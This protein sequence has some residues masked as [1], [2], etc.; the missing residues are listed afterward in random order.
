MTI[1]RTPDY[2]IPK[3]K[4]YLSECDD[5]IFERGIYHKQ[6]TG[7][8]ATTKE[9]WEQRHSILIFPNKSIAK[10][11]SE[12]PH[13]PK[14][15]VFF[16]YVGS[17]ENKK[18]TTSNEQVSSHHR[19]TSGFTKFFVVADSLPKVFKAIGE[20]EIFK[21]YFLL[22]D[23]IDKYQDQ[24]T[25]RPALEKAIDFFLDPRCNGCLL[26]ATIKHFSN[27]S[28]G[29]YLPAVISKE[30]EQD[31][32]KL[33]GRAFDNLKQIGQRLD[34]LSHENPQK[35]FVIAHKSV[36]AQLAIIS[37]LLDQNKQHCK[38]L[39]G[40]QA[41]SKAKDYYG[42]L[43]DGQ[44]PG[45]FNFITSTYF[46]GVDMYEESI[47]LMVS[48][49]NKTFS[50][51]T[52]KEV[53][54]IY[55]RGRNG[56][57]QAHL[58]INIEWAKFVKVDP[59]NLIDRA[60]KLKPILSNLLSEIKT[61]A[62]LDNS[63]EE[64]LKA[65]I[66]PIKKWNVQ[67]IRVNKENIPDIAHFPIDQYTSWNNDMSQLYSSLKSFKETLGKTFSF[68]FH[69]GKPTPADNSLDLLN[70]YID[71]LIKGKAR[72]SNTKTEKKIYALWD[73][74]KTYLQDPNEL[75]EFLHTTIDLMPKEA[76]KAMGELL[77][78]SLNDSHPLIAQMVSA[79]HTEKVFSANE[80][81][82]EIIALKYFENG[83]P[84]G[85]TVNDI[86]NMCFEVG[87][88]A[89]DGRKNGKKIVGRKESGYSI[90]PT[91]PK[92]PIINRIEEL[93][94]AYQKISM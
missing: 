68:T 90:T 16:Q 54:Q 17:G 83:V 34:E 76:I 36:D 47:L 30:E 20:E 24:S 88:N 79:L 15:N 25:F 91:N 38:I 18:E 86:I 63:A 9:M 12:T 37:H 53:I 26:T 80:M 14:L 60:E 67:L 29:E 10:L 72:D 55:G 7:I 66:V 70:E 82:T 13:D 62:E 51:L 27:P 69:D 85:I 50:P 6:G 46:S 81:K 89:K 8:G 21:K 93:G 59:C 11:K 49:R 39:C 74:V 42:E 65:T 52:E 35:K 22:F 71:T 32:L 87:L 45:R 2:T 94:L 56:W 48:D 28:L 5:F 43:K 23:E 44:L 1:T 4:D 57:R 92:A 31:K 3:D 58:L 19:R 73:F 33:T 78:E 64:I 77:F 40:S 84:P 75:K 61:V 41:K